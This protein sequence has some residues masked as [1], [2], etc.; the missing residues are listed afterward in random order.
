[1]TVTGAH[2]RLGQI[3]AKTEVIEPPPTA[4]QLAMKSL[5]GKLLYVALFFAIGIPILGVLRGQDWKLMLLTG[6][7]LAFAIIPEELPIVIT[8]VLG[9]GSY[10]LSTQ[11]FL[12]KQLRTAEVLGNVTTIVSDKTGTITNIKTIERLVGKY[13][14]HRLGKTQAATDDSDEGQEEYR[15]ARSRQYQ[16][17]HGAANTS[18]QGQAQQTRTPR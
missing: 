5:A 2:T 8:M 3:A 16:S 15:E 11:R 7:A 12:I 6:L 17:S 4:L 10:K 13:A 14:C 1:V 18:Q 9:L